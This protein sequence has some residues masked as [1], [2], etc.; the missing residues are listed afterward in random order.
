MNLLILGSGAMGTALAGIFSNSNKVDLWVRRKEAFNRIVETRENKQY[1]PTY[2]IPNSVNIITG[3]LDYNQYEAIILAFP[4]QHIRLMCTKLKL[5]TF[6]G[7]IINTAKG[8]ELK[9]FITPSEILTQIGCNNSSIYT[10]S[11]PSHAEEVAQNIP[12][13]VVLAGEELPVLKNLLQALSSPIFRPYYSHDRLGVELG[14]ALKNIIAI[15]A[16]VALGLGYGMN[17]ISAIITRGIAEIKRYGKYRKTNIETY[18]GLSCLGDLITTCCSD[19]SRNR[20]FGRSLVDNSIEYNKLAEGALT[21]QSLID[22]ISSLDFD[23]P[24][25]RAV[26]EIAINKKEPSKIM[27][28]L[29]TR[30]LK[31][32]D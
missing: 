9:T 3:A 14:G 8:L 20:E 28:Q 25:C 24:L 31:E 15:A 12:T 23:M 11:G 4:T 22:E 5:S 18:Y 27:Q 13:S 29:I 19:F 30:P 1:L 10:L 2:K 26:F 21:V 6:N 16:G 17:T 7:S 32:E